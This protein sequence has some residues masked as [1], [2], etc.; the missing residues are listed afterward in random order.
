M[1]SR[2]ASP[3]NLAVISEP[4]FGAAY[5][6]TVPA[7]RP[8]IIRLRLGKWLPRGS[9][10]G[11][12]LRNQQPFLRQCHGKIAGKLYRRGRS[13]AGADHRY[14]GP[15]CQRYVAAIGQNGRHAFQLPEQSRIFWRIVK[16]IA[17]PRLANCIYL[18][19]DLGGGSGSI[20]PPS[21]LAQIRQSLQR[22][23]CVA[24]PAQQ[25]CVADRAD[26]RGSKQPDASKCLAL[27]ES[28]FRQRCR[29]ALSPPIFG[30]IPA[31]SRP[32]FARWSHRISSVI[33]IRNGTNSGHP[34]R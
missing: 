25:L 21:S 5:T 6:T 13:I 8:A 34:V 23:H 29:H 16:Q 11:G 4:D 15:R 32:M 3:A 33:K 7:A 9:V 22:S 27:R 19:L 18:R 10:P 2:P 1:T 30:S 17:C 31:L 26:I 12:L 14:T 20:L 24:E 28:R